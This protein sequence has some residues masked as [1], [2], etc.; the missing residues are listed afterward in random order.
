MPGPDGEGDTPPQH[1]LRA[2]YRR[3]HGPRLSSEKIRVTDLGVNLERLESAFEPAFELT[4]FGPLTPRDS[5]PTAADPSARIA[6]SLHGLNLSPMFTPPNTAVDVDAARWHMTYLACVGILRGWNLTTP[7]NCFSISTS[8]DA[9]VAVPS[10]PSAHHLVN[11]DTV[12]RS[13]RG[14]RPRAHLFS[15]PCAW[16]PGPSASTRPV[17]ARRR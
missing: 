4:L 1:I 17:P 8:S 6:K 10:G 14:T 11:E 15:P 12:W 9:S 13:S 2:G 3:R 16:S 7:G 5:A